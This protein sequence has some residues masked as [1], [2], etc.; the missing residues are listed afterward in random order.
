MSS[1][2]PG[3]VGG[4][5]RITHSDKRRLSLYLA[6]PT[7]QIDSDVPLHR[8]EALVRSGKNFHQDERVKLTIVFELFPV[9]FLDIVV[10]TDDFVGTLATACKS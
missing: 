10:V 9:D 1:W 5:T 6:E 8:L 3:G 2:G 7:R 4:K